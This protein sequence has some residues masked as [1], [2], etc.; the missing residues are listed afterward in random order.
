MRTAIWEF[1]S[2]PGYAFWLVKEPMGG[3]ENPLLFDIQ[4]ALGAHSG[5]GCQ[6]GEH[7]LC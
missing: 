4:T 6:L 1:G 5:P 2:G 7:A 3:E